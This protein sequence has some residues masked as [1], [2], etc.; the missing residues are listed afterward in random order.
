MTDRDSADLSETLGY[1]RAL[2]EEG[3]RDRTQALERL[4]RI[5]QQQATTTAVLERVE[6]HSKLVPGLRAQ[7]R[8][9]ED[10]HGDTAKAVEGLTT[11]VTSLKGWRKA[12]RYWLMGIAAS[13]GVLGTMA[14]KAADL[15]GGQ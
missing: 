13:G 6:G 1:M 8:A 3:N 15:F 14:G 11:D 2:L 5:E 12:I 4:S 7:V 9:L 10:K